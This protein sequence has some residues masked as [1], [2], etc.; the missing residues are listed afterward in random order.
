MRKK[1]VCGNWKMYKSAAETATLLGQ[2]KSGWR[3]DFA[4]VDTAVFP[5]Y[6]SLS[7]ARDALADSSIRYGA[8]NCYYVAEGAFTGEISPGMLRAEGCD[9]VILGH[10]ER[11]TIFCESDDLIAKKTRAVLDAGMIAVVCIGETE[12]ERNSDETVGVI[13]RQIRD[14]LFGIEPEDLGRIVIAYEPVWAIGTGKTA[15]P[16]QAEAAHAFTRR[17]L[18]ERFGPAGED[19][20]ILYGGSVKADN[21]RELFAQPNI[22][23]GLIGGASLK[24]E[25]FLAIV[26]AAV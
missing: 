1:L 12:A 21:A 13:E 16:D 8:Q 7:I 25:S 22:D 14:S 24:A 10:S 20:R 15:S 5:P 2:L 4:V 9:Y 18:V 11:R 19:V 3:D 6:T 17:E 23:G 26:E